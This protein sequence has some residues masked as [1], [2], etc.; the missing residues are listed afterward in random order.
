MHR[1]KVIENISR[2]KPSDFG[3]LLCI[4]F[5]L[6]HFSW[7]DSITILLCVNQP[8]K[9]NFKLLL[10]SHYSVDNVKNIEETNTCIYEGQFMRPKIS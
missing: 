1:G 5:I 9:F 8:F 3:I 6:S 4:C 10:S 7:N 2:R